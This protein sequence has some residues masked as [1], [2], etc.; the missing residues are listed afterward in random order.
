MS[1]D[2]L[3]VVDGDY[4]WFLQWYLADDGEMGLSIGELKNKELGDE[5]EDR[6]DWENWIAHKIAEKSQGVY[7]QDGVLFWDSRRAAQGALKQIK[8]AWKTRVRE[9]PEWARTALDAG[10]KP[11]KDWKP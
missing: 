9:L 3:V 1:K 5:P 11:P 6:E 4:R 7:R 2:R 10:W 8:L